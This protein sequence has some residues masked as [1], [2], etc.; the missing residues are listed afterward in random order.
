MM[1]KALAGVC[2]CIFLCGSLFA[3]AH[4][5][6]SLE[7][8]VYYILEQGEMRGL[9]QPLSGGRPY[10]QSVVVTA[11]DEIL[12]TD[13]AEK[14]SDTER[15]ILEQYLGKFSKPK[16]GFDW[17]RGAWYG[18]T[19]LGKND[20]PITGNIG[21]SAEVEGSTGLYSS[22]AERH[23]GTETWVQV[24]VNGDLGLYFSYKFI[25]EGGLM[26]APRKWLGKY[27]TY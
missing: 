3:Q 19:A 27:D 18:E 26:Q 16:D 24:L 11:I 21:I 9:C 2:W 13:K 4:S 8:Q 10:T 25:F 5:S 17:K 20:V 6:V 23:F 15:E 7:N 12:N 22:F 14:L 1:K